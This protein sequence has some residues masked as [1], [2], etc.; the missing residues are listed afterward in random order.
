[1]R[2]VQKLSLHAPHLFGAIDSPHKG[3]HR[4][5]R[6]EKGNKGEIVLGFSYPKAIERLREK[7]VEQRG[8]H[9]R[10]NRG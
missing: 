8:A 5:R 2:L 1:M 10:E 4:N 9:K 7:K 6:D 3:Y